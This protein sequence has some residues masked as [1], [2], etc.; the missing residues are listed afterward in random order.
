LNFGPA[1]V[2]PNNRN[3]GHLVCNDA[4]V[5]DK[6]FGFAF[7][8]TTTQAGLAL[9]ATTATPSTGISII[10]TRPFTWASGDSLAVQLFYEAAA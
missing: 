4:S 8:G 9:L 1:S 2:S 3:I 6:W 10:A 7:Q 5:A